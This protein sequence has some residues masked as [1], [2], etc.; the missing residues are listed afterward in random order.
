MIWPH[1][2]L[3][4]LTI[5]SILIG[6][7]TGLV[8]VVIIN[9]LSVKID[10]LNGNFT[11]LNTALVKSQSDFKKLEDRVDGHD[12]TLTEHSEQIKTLFRK[13]V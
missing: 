9:P 13:E 5:G 10:E 1:D 3:S 7:L 2:V 6:V 12:L 8:K 11:T 4:W